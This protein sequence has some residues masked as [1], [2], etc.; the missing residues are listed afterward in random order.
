MRDR[1]GLYRHHGSVRPT[2]PRCCGRST[3]RTRCTDWLCRRKIMGGSLSFLVSHQF[4][5][6]SMGNTANSS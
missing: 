5:S 4:L 1:G 6:C 3:R 2:H